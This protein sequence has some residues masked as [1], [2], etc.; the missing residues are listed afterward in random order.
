MYIKQSNIEKPTVDRFTL[1][2]TSPERLLSTENNGY[3]IGTPSVTILN[4][5]QC[6]ENLN[7]FELSLSGHRCLCSFTRQNNFGTV[8]MKMVCL[9]LPKRRFGKNRFCCVH[10]RLF[11]THAKPKSNMYAQLACI[12]LKPLF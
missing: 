6:K 4:D 2:L 10:Y 5:E 7:T 11:L 1:T 8:Y 3:Y 12:S 9:Q